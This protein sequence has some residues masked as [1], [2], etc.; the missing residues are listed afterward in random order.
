[1]TLA[2]SE[3]SIDKLDLLRRQID[4]RGVAALA[5]GAVTEPRRVAADGKDDHI[6]LSCRGDGGGDVGR[7]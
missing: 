6:G 1:M 5:L 3:H 2:D 7:L 4:V